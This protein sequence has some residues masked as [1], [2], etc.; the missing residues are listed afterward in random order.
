M[1]YTMVR[2]VVHPASTSVRTF[3]FRSSNRKQLIGASLAPFSLGT[4]NSLTRSTPSPSSRDAIFS[5]PPLP[6]LIISL[7]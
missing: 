5:R 7:L 2:N 6:F 3:V 1:M 4:Y